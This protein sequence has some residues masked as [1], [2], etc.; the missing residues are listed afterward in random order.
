MEDKDEQSPIRCILHAWKAPERPMAGIKHD[1]QKSDGHK[2]LQVS[3]SPLVDRVP[4]G[5]TIAKANEPDCA[6]SILRIEYPSAYGLVTSPL[7][8]CVDNAPA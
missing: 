3:N 4:P 5:G 8:S 7:Y 1:D 2:Q 6:Y